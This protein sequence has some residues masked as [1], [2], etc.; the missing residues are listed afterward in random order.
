MAGFYLRPYTCAP[1]I[2]TETETHIEIETQR[3][4]GEFF[5]FTPAPKKKKPHIKPVKTYL[6]KSAAF[7]HW[8]TKHGQEKSRELWIG[9]AEVAI[10]FSRTLGQT[11]NSVSLR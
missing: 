8:T 2:T 10:A 4:T 5:L 9:L 11:Y 7:I 6:T 1:N 3:E